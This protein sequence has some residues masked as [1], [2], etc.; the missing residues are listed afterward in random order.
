MNR[1]Y[2]KLWRKSIDAGWLSNH[3]LWAFWCWCLM[4]ASHKEYELIVGCQKVHLMPGD[5]IFG[6]KKV[7]KE[8]KLSEQT[9]RTFLDFLKTSQNITIR[10]TNKFSVISIVNWRTYQEEENEINQQINQPL[11]SNQPATNHKQECKELKKKEYTS[12]FLEFYTAYPKHK[13]RDDA[14]KAWR[15]LNGTRP[16]LAEILSAIEKQKE[17]DDWKK[18]N[19]KWIPF[20]ATWLRAGRWDD[21][22]T[23]KCGLP[24]QEAWEI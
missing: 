19:G 24:K 10:T 22:T 11:T 21:E 6:R 3:K 5:L 1:G 17:S 15:S 13:A 20:P 2:V 23:V 16:P 7:S 4:K 12:E 14:Y 18:D 9:I 8:L